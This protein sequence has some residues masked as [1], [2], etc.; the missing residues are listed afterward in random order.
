M[1]AVARNVIRPQEGY[2][3]KALSSSADIV[4]GGGAAGAG[5][6]FSLLLDPLRDI[7]TKDFG[8]VI[9]RRTTPQIRNQGG[10]WDTSMGLYIH[11]GGKPKESTLEWDWPKGV[12]IKF[13]HLEYE[14]NKFDWQGSQIP[15]IAF[16]ELTHFSKS[17]FF[18]ML[19]R[20]RS[21]CGVRPYVR[22][23]CNPDPESWVAEL[24][25][26]WIDQETGFPIPERDGVIRYFVVY[27]D[28]YI[29]GDT[30]KEVIEKA[31]H[32]LE[33]VATKS[34]INP[35]EL[36]KS[37]TFVSG[38]V[39][40][41]VALLSENP[42]YI[43]NLLSQD[44]A[45][46]SQLLDGNWKVRVSDEDIYNYYD[47]IGCF[48]NKYIVQKPGRFITADIALQGRDKLIFLFWNGRIVEDIEII[49]ISDGKNVV[50][51]L[52]QFAK[53]HKV[54]NN[55]ICY[56]ADGVGAYLDGFI[57]GSVAFHG[58]I[59]AKKVVDPISL[60]MI[61]E[62]Y[63]NLKTQC[64]YRSGQSVSAGE[65]QISEE[66]AGR[67]YDEKMTV[68]QRFA[69]ERK[70]IKKYKMDS[71]GKKQMNPKAEQKLK[72]NGQSPDLMDAFMMREIFDLAT[73]I[74]FDA[75]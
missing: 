38:S 52:E 75:G 72:L 64:Y 73:E 37:L 1:A 16:D 36:V 31:W 70:A 18:Y 4:I 43:G 21:T 62:N 32:Y 59:P 8:G 49:S 15:F 29:W 44:D 14:K 42:E 65:T 57:R 69:F 25:E 30:K 20:N 2:Q 10:L 55:K 45:T 6:T 7:N 23:T 28:Q 71:D 3:M 11:A 9:F 58:G 13:A 68:R 53:K 66:V 26:W 5:K 24:I 63:K 12:K 50:D 61:Q 41:N 19:S 54:P 22:A 33:P 27:S 35:N 47:F 34:K 39:Y 67:M 51:K 74:F 56:D 17:T 60:K 40:D 46:R 48:E